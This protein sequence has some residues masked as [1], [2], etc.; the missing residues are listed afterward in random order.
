[1]PDISLSLFQHR[2]HFLWKS[3]ILTKFQG[4]G[5]LN[6]WLGCW[7]TGEDQET[8]SNLTWLFIKSFLGHTYN[9]TTLK[10]SMQNTLSTITK[11]NLD[12]IDIMEC[13]GPKETSF[14]EIFCL[15]TAAKFW[16]CHSDSTGVGLASTYCQ[17]NT[18]GSDPVW[19]LTALSAISAY[20][21]SFGLSRKVLA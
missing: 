8:M 11:T 17:Q 21:R 18:V 1:M 15:R 9:K 20:L 2:R 6:N 19:V 10:E 12:H 7:D 16:T 13:Q 5:L 14:H 3:N 4:Q